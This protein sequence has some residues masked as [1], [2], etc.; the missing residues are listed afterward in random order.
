MGRWRLI[1][2]VAVAAWAA[3]GAAASAEEGATLGKDLAGESCNFTGPAAAAEIRTLPIACNGQEGAG[4]VY[5]APF[6]AR[7]GDAPAARRAA[8]VAAAKS[9]PGGLGRG[10]QIRCDDGTP[11]APDS[12]SL[13]F[14]CTLASNG[15]PRVVLLAQL[16]SALYQGEGLPA[17]LPV[18]QAAIAQSAGRALPP[19]DTEG[20]LR[21]L[22]QRFPG[23]LAH[24]GGADLASTGAR[25]GRA[26]RR[27]AARLCR[28]RGEL[29]PR[30]RD[31]DAAVRRR[32]H[33]RR[34]DAG[35]AGAPGQ[36]PGPLRRGRRP[37]PPRRADDRCRRQHRAARAAR[38]LSRAR[39]GEPAQFRRSA[40]IR[41]RRDG[42]AA[43]RARRAAIGPGDRRQRGRRAGEPRR[44]RPQPA[45]RG[46][47]GDAARRPADRARR[48]RGS[49]AHRQRGA[50]PAAVVAR[51]RGGDD[52]RDQRQA[53]P[54]RAGRAPV[55]R[56]DTHGQRCSATPRPPPSP[57]SSS[58]R[59]YA[60]QQV[61][62]ASVAMFRS[63][64]DILGRSDVARAGIVPDQIVPFFAAARAR[65][66]DDANERA[67]LETEMFRA[68][69]I[70]A[71]DV[72]GRTI[73]R[74]AARLAADDP[75]SADL[76]RVADEAQRERD[77]SRMA[78]AA[79]TA[80]PDDQRDAAR[81]RQIVG[82]CR[83]GDEARG[84]AH[85][86][87][88]H[89][90]SRLR[91]ARRSRPGGASRAAG[92]ARRG[93]GVPQLRHRHDGAYALLVTSRRAQRRAPR[94]D[95]R[96]AREGRGRA[97][98]SLRAAARR[99]A[100]FR[101]RRRL[102]ALPPP[103]RPAR[104]ETRRGRSS[105]RRAERRAGEPAARAAG[106]GRR[107]R[108]R[109]P[110]MP[111][112]RGWCGSSRSARCRRPRA[113]LALR[114][115]G[116]RRTPAPKPLLAVADPSF[117]GAAAGGERAGRA[118]RRAAASDGPVPADLIRAL[119][120]L[121]E[122]AG[123]VRSGRRGSWARGD[124]RILLGAAATEA[125]FRAR[126]LD[127]YAVLYFATHGLL[128]G[129]LHCQ[130][131]PGLVLSPPPLARAR[132]RR[133]RT[134]R[135]QR[136]RRTQAQRRSRRAVGLQHRG[137]GGSSAAG[138][139][140]ASPRRSSMPARAPSSRATGRCRRS[141]PRS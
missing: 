72:A 95:R 137:A 42:D 30:A 67:Q 62:T 46:A 28:R 38:V 110:T 2:C 94:R 109:G 27:G 139:S 83:G 40:Q 89:P 21:L 26:A 103:S 134:A 100:R 35:G 24:A 140:R 126:P 129:E 116:A 23:T 69:Q 58:A 78:L 56:R 9:M 71:S 44:A 131:E 15:F 74:A 77:A 75:S 93:R 102:R 125:N 25:R 51:R 117:A 50:E 49:A 14:A 59:F 82:R 61:Y 22:D 41:A 86:P 13:L 107:R 88:R 114:A 81:D 106:D 76:M 133:G 31:R 113:F 111:M 141:R 85:A 20:A 105:D 112:R 37:L 90:I 1:A 8:L 120:P 124:E 19:A 7:A 87:D 122:T 52:G 4:A 136:D 6:A 33:R 66:K 70:V 11:V 12:D 29:S 96:A 16:G 60:D 80:K 121:P 127:Q 130:S 73:A 135:R 98:P 101:S 36:Q 104:G 118:R 10:A 123:E 47:D 55:P 18:L 92:A 54:H 63:A 138:R 39:R 45:H 5:V 43:R 128:P 32:Q 84:R 3:G 57:S 17:V 97:A 68:S 119:P 115:A 99:P 79:E 65:A 53:G 34:R 108:A 91:T 64:F 132:R 48:R